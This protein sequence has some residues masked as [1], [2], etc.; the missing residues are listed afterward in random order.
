MPEPVVRVS[1]FRCKPEDFARL[2]TMMGEAEPV[3]RPGSE[4][5]D[6]FLDFLAGA[7][8]A[9]H[10]LINTSFWRTLAAAQQLDRYE[11]MLALGREF[12]AAGAQFER[13][14]MNYGLLWRFGDLAGP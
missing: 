2:N 10:S 5:M 6:G 3:L 8:E 4:A 9:T 14:V 12:V 7:D 11:P 1:F 13:P